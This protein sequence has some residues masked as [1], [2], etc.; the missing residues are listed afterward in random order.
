MSDAVGIRMPVFK[1]R[2]SQDENLQQFRKKYGKNYTSA[3][4]KEE[5]GEVEGVPWVSYEN[6]RGTWM[7]HY[8]FGYDGRPMLHNFDPNQKVNILVTTSEKT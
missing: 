7:V 2:K 3:G 5:L 8:S 4:W 1:D 6:P